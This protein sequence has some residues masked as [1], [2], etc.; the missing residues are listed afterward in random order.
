M[1]GN[2]KKRSLLSWLPLW[3]WL[4]FAL[5]A[6]TADAP[7][8]FPTAA[9][10]Y[11]RH[12]VPSAMRRD[13]VRLAERYQSADWTPIPDSLFAEFRKNG[14]R[15]H[16]EEVSFGKRRQLACLVMGEIMQHKG[17]FLP[18]IRNGLHYFMDQETWWGLPAH[19]PLSRPERNR[20]VV[21][22]F[23]AETASMLAWTVY[24]LGEDID[25]EEPGLTRQMKE[26]ITRRFLRPTLYERQGWKRN[27][28]NWNTW[29]TSNWLECVML[30]ETDSIRRGEALNGIHANLRLFLSRYPDDGGC[31]EGV[32]YWDRAGASFFESLYFLDA[33]SAPL[34]LT[35]AEREKVHAMGRF[36]TTMHIHNLTFVNFSDAKSKCLPNINVLFPYGAYF[37][38]E[39]MMSFAAYIGR[40]YDYLSHPST[41][42]LRTGNFPTLSRELLLLSMLPR[43]KSIP[44]VQPQTVDAYLSNSQI[45]VAATAR[46]HPSAHRWL[47]AAKGGNNGESHNHNDVGNFIVYY[48]QRPVI[49]DLGRD[50]YTSQT[51][52]NRRYELTNNRSL[53]HNVPLINGEEQAAGRNFRAQT[54]A[55]QATDTASV[56]T[57]DLAKAYPAEAKVERWTRRIVLDRKADRVELTENFSLQQPTTKATALTLMCFGKPQMEGEGRV[58]LDE[59]RVALRFDARQLSATIQKVDLGQGILHTQWK[60]NVYRLELR[61]TD[62]R[63]VQTVDYRLETNKNNIK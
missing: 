51:F 12:Q 28:N 30:C 17:R 47:V 45:M 35:E 61:V 15:I 56:M 5:A 24:M 21:D 4:P 49:V 36:L 11:W 6:S 8:L 59:G 60:D 32:D 52:S 2:L 7:R 48:D 1:K 14:N 58:L 19:Y 22:L 23:N 46:Q 26:E 54:V 3:L 62:P 27:A 16:F 50:T 55:H 41:L 13:Y 25:R 63:E 38:D 57:L 10:H 20:Q 44:A 53:Y 29:I 18:A 42:F 9:G 31:E 37:N 39:T 33:M 34:P 40:T 43:F